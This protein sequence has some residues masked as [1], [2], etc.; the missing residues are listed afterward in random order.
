MKKILVTVREFR[1][2]G[3]YLIKGR[4]LF[5]YDGDEA[6][7]YESTNS[8]DSVNADFMGCNISYLSTGIYVQIQCTPIY[9]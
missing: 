6:G 4:E 5:F 1:Q 7:L 8:Y 9:Q 3:G 2:G